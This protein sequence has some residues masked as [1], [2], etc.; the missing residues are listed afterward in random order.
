MKQLRRFYSVVSLSF[1]T[2]GAATHEVLFVLA[3]GLSRLL[4][5]YLLQ[6]LSNAT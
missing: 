4:S 6:S 2:I 1:C 3:L 5:Y